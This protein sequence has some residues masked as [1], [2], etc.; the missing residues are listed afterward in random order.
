MKE[1]VCPVPE[2]KTLN[3]ELKIKK[4]ACPHTLSFLI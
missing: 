4:L 1:V 3:A 2:L